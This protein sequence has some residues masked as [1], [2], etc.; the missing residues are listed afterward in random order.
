MDVKVCGPGRPLALDAAGPGAN[1][2][3]A[4]A[5]RVENRQGVRGARF[6]QNRDKDTAA[7]GQGIE[8]AAVMR[9]KSYAA[10]CPG[11]AELRQVACSAG[12]QRRHKRT[13]RQR[14]ADAGQ[15]H[16]QR[17]GA[18]RALDERGGVGALF[19]HDRQRLG[20]ETG[21]LEGVDAFLRPRDVLKDADGKPFCFR[22][23]HDV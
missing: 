2:G 20:R 10:H 11:K 5:V 9:L 18:E 17:G 15:F 3:V 16:T 14:G 13:M 19:H 23:N 6:C 8:N 22:L 21:L 12:L 7:A 1:G 4:A